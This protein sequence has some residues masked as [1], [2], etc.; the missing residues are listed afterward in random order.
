MRIETAVNASDLRMIL[1][2]TIQK[3]RGDIKRKNDPP[4]QISPPFSSSSVLVF[5]NQAQAAS[6]VFLPALPTAR[7]TLDDP[8]RYG[9]YV[10]VVH[11]GRFC[12]RAFEI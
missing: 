8:E 3:N 11:R 9:D 6:A 12:C 5:K 10:E 7:G 2:G 1:A 4:K